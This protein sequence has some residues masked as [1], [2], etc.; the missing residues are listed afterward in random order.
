MATFIKLNRPP[1][2]FGLP[3]QYKGWKEAIDLWIN[4]RPDMFPDDASKINFSLSYMD[5]AAKEWR[6]AYM[7]DNQHNNAYAPG[8]WDAFQTS[9]RTSFVPANEAYISYT[10]LSKIKQGN[11]T[12]SEYISRFRTLN[13]TAGITDPNV[14][15][16]NF[17]Q[18]LQTPLLYQTIALNPGNT[19]QNWYDQARLADQIL[20]SQL[21]TRAT[22]YEK[23]PAKNLRHHRFK[24]KNS[25]VP[26]NRTPQTTERDPYAMDIDRIADRINRLEFDD[27]ATE[28]ADQEEEDDTNNH[29]D[30]DSD[31]DQERV[32]RIAKDL[33]SETLNT[34][35]T[36]DQRRNLKARRCFNCDQP[37]HFAR[38]CPKKPTRRSHLPR[39]FDA[40]NREGRK[41]RNRRYEKSKAQ[42]I[43]QIVSKLDEEEAKEVYEH[44]ANDVDHPASDMVKDFA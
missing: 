34:I 32:L 21:A 16:Y 23:H 22:H 35:L 17:R 10:Q 42:T 2:F 38:E 24:K 39:N 3:E 37:G 25:F 28:E 8:T 19:I 36:P 4:T 5:G 6:S 33:V 18:G 7:Q 11:S 15:I 30:S 1:T 20:Q 13:H 14:L 29:E 27:I 41:D 9:L 40:K 31:D 12:L 43:H 26:Y 44:F